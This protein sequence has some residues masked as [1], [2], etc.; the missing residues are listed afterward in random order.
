VRLIAHIVTRNEAGRYLAQCLGWLETFADEINVFDDFSADETV[1]VC[2]LAGA[3]VTQRDATLM[4]FLEHEGRF[5]SAAWE[6]LAA[7]AEPGDWV[8]ADEFLVCDPGIPLRAALEAACRD[9]ELADANAIR[10]KKHEVFALDDNTHAP[11]IRT[12]GFWHNVLTERFAR[13]NGDTVFADVP[14]ASGSVPTTAT[15]VMQTS[16][17]SLLHYGY[18]AAE[19]RRDRF[20]RYNGRV[21]H[22]PKHVRSILEPPTLKP[23]TGMH[24]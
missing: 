20:E 4:S 8:F 12:D 22:S 17:V 3:H 23:W 24:P 19:D 9:A 6:T 18:A 1:R 10:I 5:R 16:T 2:E 14:L 13:W 11:L 7:I 15:P 21:G